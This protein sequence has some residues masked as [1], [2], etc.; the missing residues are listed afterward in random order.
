M[1]TPPDLCPATP[2]AISE[3]LSYALR[4][5][6]RRRVH[7]ADNMLARITADRLVQHLEASGFVV[8]RRPAA[9]APTT[10][11]MPAPGKG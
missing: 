2:E 7:H 9:G 4:Y 6:G 8:M 3:A 11:R 1:D 5:E 10:S